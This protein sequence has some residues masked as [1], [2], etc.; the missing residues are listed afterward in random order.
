MTF[1]LLNHFALAINATNA[2]LNFTMVVENK[3]V[4]NFTE[5]EIWLIC[6]QSFD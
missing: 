3:A 5:I 1:F 6:R 4:Q 2:L